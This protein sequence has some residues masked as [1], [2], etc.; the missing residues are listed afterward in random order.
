MPQIIEGI[1]TTRNED[2]TTNVAPMG[3]IVR[4]DWTEFVFRP[5]PT[6]VTYHNLKRTGQGVFHVT[7][8]VRL[9]VEAALDLPSPEREFQPASRVEGE[10]LAQ[11]CRWYEVEVQSIDESGQRPRMAA[12]V[13]AEGRI[14]DFCGFNRAKHAIVEATILATRLHLLTRGEVDRQIAM[15]GVTVEKTASP[16]DAEVFEIVRRFVREHVPPTPI[17]A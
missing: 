3:P 9:I 2:G 4:P 1:L 10:V 17:E 11:T 14:R 16:E 8:D 13:V 6:S 15:L 7:D 5:F 12:R